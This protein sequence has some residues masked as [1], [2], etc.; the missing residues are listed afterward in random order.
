[1]RDRRH[2]LFALVLVLCMGEA[3]GYLATSL[4]V[5]PD[6]TGAV[7]LAH[8]VNPLMESAAIVLLAAAG[9]RGSPPVRR[10]CRWM[11]VA[12][13][14]A[15]VGDAARGLLDAAGSSVSDRGS[16]IDLFDVGTALAMTGAVYAKFG[17]PLRYWRPL[18][19]SS[20]LAL[21][22]GYVTLTVVVQPQLAHSLTTVEVLAAARSVAMLVAGLAAVSALTTSNVRPEPGA[23][24]IAI[25]IPVQALTSLLYAAYTTVGPVAE[26]SAI[27]VGFQLGWA[28]MI[29]GAAALL[30]WRR[31]PRRITLPAIPLIT[32]T[33]TYGLIIL[34]AAVMWHSRVLEADPLGVTVAWLGIV[35]VLARL[36]LTIRERGAM[37][38]EMRVLAETD[39]LSGL[40]NRRRFD[41]RLDAAVA[42]H[43]AGGLG[44]AILVIDVDRF[45]RV[46]DGY[47]H[48]VGDEV[49]V[50]LAGRIRGS[51]RPADILARVGGEEF[52]A[53]LA[54]VDGEALAEVAERCRHRV[55]REPVRVQGFD[56]PVT[57]SVGGA[58]LPDHAR[59]VDELVRVADRG[60]Y[61]A[62]Q[63]G[64]N[65]VHVGPASTP[66]R[67]I[68]IP[69]LGVIGNLESLADRLDGAQALQEHSMAMVDVA[70]RL[71]GALGVSTAQRRR[72]LGAA[73]LHDVG[74]VGTP[75]HILGKPGPLT[76]AE[77]VV[78]Q[79]HVRVGVE[80]L[81]AFSTTREFAAI[82]AEHHERF[83]GSGYPAGLVGSQISLEAR[84]IAVADAWTAMLA[85]RPY[86][87]ALPAAAARAELLRC[88]GSHFDPS[89]V[90]AFMDLV[91]T[92]GLA[93]PSAHAVAA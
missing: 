6:G 43:A 88:A 67:Q 54:G 61:E 68:P 26:G 39:P 83:D 7:V 9:L 36:H 37:A 77:Q 8:I 11:A 5:A 69:E 49:L 24:L 74:K 15:L 17:S 72:C 19:D 56:I 44:V 91:D 79:D 20:I 41:E 10:F 25:A 55:A 2:A 65:R 53:L 50:A 57:I 81:R 12:A 51:L 85:D 14:F 46:N 31:R 27:H 38:A 18:L 76:A 47:G 78:M 22:V 40:P 64:R 30:I 73:R 59:S 28:F 33:T 70:E 84:I 92:G 75:P 29:C 34:L 62:K 93:E 45:K 60:L 58:S 16:A 87:A 13:A 90:A 48:P 35:T 86:R 63:A 32:M 21:V 52:G 71:C 23:A 1:V 3:A 80:I 4:A 42:A 66:Q 89:I 82:V